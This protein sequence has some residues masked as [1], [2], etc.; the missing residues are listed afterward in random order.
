MPVEVFFRRLVPTGAEYVTAPREALIIEEV[1]FKDEGEYKFL[2]DRKETTPLLGPLPFY[3]DT[4]TYGS[5]PLNLN[6]LPVVVPPETAWSVQGTPATTAL[7]LGRKVQ[8]GIGEALPDEVTRRFAEQYSRYIRIYKGSISL[9]V[10]Q[11]WAAGAELTAL[12]F[13][14]LANERVTFSGPVLARWSGFTLDPGAVAVRFYMDGR[15]L[16]NVYRTG[17]E[18]G[19]DLKTL[20]TVSEYRNYGAPLF[21]LERLPIVVNPNTVFT[22]TAE[23]ISGADIAPASGQAIS[24]E[25]WLLAV[26]EKG[27][28]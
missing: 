20:T 3:D 26:Y 24:V 16:E 11:A 17:W 10:N 4:K 28:G 23:N 14:T 19:I 25:L 7:L 18:P 12:Q 1:G 22:V 8:L 5:K 9:A 6:P 21:S 2:I 27:V 15:P 13:T